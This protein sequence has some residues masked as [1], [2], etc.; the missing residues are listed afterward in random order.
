MPA[1]VVSVI[2]FTTFFTNWHG[3]IDSVTTYLLNPV[4]ERLIRVFGSFRES[5]CFAGHTHL[6]NHF[7]CHDDGQVESLELTIGVTELTSARSIILPGSVGQPRDNHSSKAK[8]AIWDQQWAT[9]EIREIE[10]DVD[11]TC[12]L[13]IERGFPE[14]NARRLKW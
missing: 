12:R 4:E 2:I 1:A 14:T 11:T 9:I 8:Y 5:L 7:I 13:I 6:L 3:V 10:Y